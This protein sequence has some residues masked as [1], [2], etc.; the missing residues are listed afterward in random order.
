[1]KHFKSMR[2]AEG[3]WKARCSMTS[4]VTASSRPVLVM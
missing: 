2:E 3:A 4:L 1:M